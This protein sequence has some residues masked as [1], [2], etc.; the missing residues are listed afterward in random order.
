MEFL[1]DLKK[2]YHQNYLAL[3]PNHSAMFQHANGSREL[4]KT[5]FLGI[6]G[7]ELEIVK[8]FAD[9]N[10]LPIHVGVTA[11][12]DHDGRK[13]VLAKALNA[14]LIP[15]YGMFGAAWATIAA[16]ALRFAI[17]Y[18]RSQKAY[19]VRYPWGKVGLLALIFAA[20]L[21]A[22]SFANGLH[23]FPSLAVSAALGLIVLGLLASLLSAQERNAL[24]GLV[25]QPFASLRSTG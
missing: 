8:H 1:T 13:M 25:R 22:R 3:C 16:Y 14:L 11:M 12:S 5:M 19:P 18:E 4:M 23:F 24:H 9:E 7:N 6:E 2:H 17:I 10:T 20:V 21:V 15:R